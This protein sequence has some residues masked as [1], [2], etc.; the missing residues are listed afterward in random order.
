M[1]QVVLI[2]GDGIGPEITA[3]VLKILDAA[4]A[5]VDWVKA[6]A[7]MTAFENS[8][9]PLPEETLAKIREHRIVLKGPLTTPVGSGFRSINVS[10]RQEFNLFSN[11]RPARSLPGIDTPFKDVDLVLFRENT[12]GL[13]SGIERWANEDHTRAE[14]IALITREASENII[15]AAFDYATK[16]KRKKVTLVHKANILKLSTG[17]FLKVGNEIAQQYPDIEYEDLIVDNMAMQMVMNPSRFDVVVTTN[18]FGD[19]LSDLASGLV[20]GLGLTGSANIGREHAMF[21]AVHGSAPDI[22]GQ[23]KANPTA[24]LFSAI[25]M[26]EHIGQNDVGARINDAIMKVLADKDACTAD[27]GGKSSTGAYG[28]AV[29]AAMS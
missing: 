29:I 11:I 4:G 25:L 19:I 13:Y 14:S 8:G 27:L 23:G 18:L 24:L 28:D 5:Q 12:Q 22:A 9:N 3:A 17:L 16:H 7:G 2:P 26:L 1:N 20:G 6:E 15:G 10:L 21:E